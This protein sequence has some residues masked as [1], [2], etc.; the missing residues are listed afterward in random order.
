MN[1]KTAK[2]HHK[3]RR[4]RFAIYTPPKEV[5]RL[6]RAAFA[7]TQPR[8]TPAWMRSLNAATGDFLQETP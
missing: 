5:T 4:E 2:P 3:K 8:L 1:P 7:K 6:K